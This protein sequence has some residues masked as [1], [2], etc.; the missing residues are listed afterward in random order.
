MLTISNQTCDDVDKGI[1]W[2]PAPYPL[3]MLICCCRFRIRWKARF[4]YFTHTQVLRYPICGITQ[5]AH[6]RNI[7]TFQFHVTGNTQK[8]QSRE[9]FEE[10]IGKTKDE[11]KDTTHFGKLCK[12][13][14]F[15]NQLPVVE[16][17]VA[18][19]P[20]NQDHNQSHSPYLLLLKPVAYCQYVLFERTIRHKHLFKECGAD[21]K[22]PGTRI[23]DFGNTFK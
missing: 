7:Q 13:M 18:L 6:F 3:F 16:S 1:K 20:V 22:T 11:H 8:F 23:P 5:C 15:P 14:R 2:N 12:F 4:V 9:H 10:R 19:V 21:G 17:K